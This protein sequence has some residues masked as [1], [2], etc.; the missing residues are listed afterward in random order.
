VVML[1]GESD[2]ERK[3][4]LFAAGAADYV[5]KPFHPRELLARVQVHLRLKLLRQELLETNRHLAELSTTD[6][7]TGLRNRRRFDEA[8]ELEI[9]RAT[10]YDVPLSLAMVDLDHFKQVNDTYGHPVGDRVLAGVGNILQSIVRTSDVAA[11]YGGEELAIILPHTSVGS[12]LVLGERVRSA[13]ESARFDDADMRVTASIG[14][15]CLASLTEKTARALV[16]SADAAVYAA[17]DAG[18]NAVH[19][20]ARPQTGAFSRAEVPTGRFRRPSP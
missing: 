19:V 12:A 16:M 4:S 14:V 8:L 7:L 13:I 5:T 6:A 11:R 17:K 15:S 10:R 1:T 18:R 3:A 20:G 2:P 9:V